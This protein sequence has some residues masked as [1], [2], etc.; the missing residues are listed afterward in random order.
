MRRCRKSCS[1]GRWPVKRTK[2]RLRGPVSPGSQLDQA[3]RGTRATH[4]LDDLGVGSDCL[5]QGRKERLGELLLCRR[6]Q[7]S[8]VARRR[9][10]RRRRSSGGQREGAHVR[11]GCSQGPGSN[12]SVARTCTGASQPERIAVRRAPARSASLG[13]CT[14]SL[15]PPSPPLCR[16][17]TGRV[18]SMAY[19]SNGLAAL[20]RSPSWFLEDLLQR[21]LT[22]ARGARSGP[23]R[24]CLFD[25]M[26][27]ACGTIAVIVFVPLSI[28][29]TGS[30]A[31]CCHVCTVSCRPL[32]PLQRSGFK[33]ES[34]M[35]QLR[36]LF[37]RL[38][39]PSWRRSGCSVQNKPCRPERISG[40]FSPPQSCTSA[41]SP[42]LASDVGSI[43]S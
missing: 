29:S 1:A 36:L 12:E 6:E 26:C 28:W 16:S 31:R 7:Q 30:A 9:S 33:L 11:H 21:A 42:K 8:R 14:A 10:A 34:C 24:V 13:C 20:Y 41:L 39:R 25:T 2:R 38:P 37:E 19:A 23:F 4:G 18:W 3:R 5:L 43:P 32:S 17:I 35:Y 40:R 27:S 22:H 15:E